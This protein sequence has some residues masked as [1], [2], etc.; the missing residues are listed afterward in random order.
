MPPTRRDEPEIDKKSI[1]RGLLD[2]VWPFTY[3]AILH[4]SR[5]DSRVRGNDAS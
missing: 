4:H 3:I 5:L 1:D 2:E